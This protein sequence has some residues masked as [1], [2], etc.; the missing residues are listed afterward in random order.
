MNV[1]LLIASLVAVAVGLAGIWATLKF[2][3][4]GGERGRDAR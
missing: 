4:P 3:P 2:I 1:P